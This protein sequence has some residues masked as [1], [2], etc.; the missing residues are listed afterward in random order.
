MSEKNGA[1]LIDRYVFEVTR[2][3]PQ[4]KRDDIEK[5]LRTLIDDMLETRCGGNVPRDEDVE[6][7]LK[8]LGRPSVLAAKYRDEKRYLIGPDVF[9]IYLLVVKIVLAAVGGGIILSQVIGYAVTP[10]DNAFAAIGSFFTTL[11]A[12]LVQAFAWVTVAFTLIERFVKKDTLKKEMEWNPS[13]LPPV[14][15][16]KAIIKKGDPIA[17]I[18]FGV[19]FLII[20]NVVAGIFGIFV[21]T[22]GKTFIPVFDL[23]A[24]EAMLPL[25]DVMVV[26]GILKDIVKLIVGRYNIQVALSVT[27]LNICSVILF[28]YVFAGPAVWN[29]EF[30]PQ[31]QAM[32]G[33]GDGFARFWNALPKVLA[34][35]AILGNVVDMITAWARAL[36]HRAAAA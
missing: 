11:L 15:E 29:A 32:F 34:G 18:V 16:N 25:I 1:D 3:L 26:L 36:R 6:A 30:M 17:G 14:P 9:E 23:D 4:A 7:V 28:I 5:E 24:I 10:P 33:W 22:D 20:L 2:R 19:V 8:E 13:D 35:L 27:V 21:L 12:A 31:A